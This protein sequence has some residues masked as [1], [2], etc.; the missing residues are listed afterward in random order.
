MKVLITGGTGLVGGS[1]SE[2]LLAQN[3]EVIIMSRSIKKSETKGLSYAHWDIDKETIE[4]D[5]V[6]S[7]DHIIHLAGANIGDK[8]WTSKQKEIMID[9]R[10]KT[11]NLLFKTLKENNHKVKTFISASGADCYGLETTDKYYQETDSF[12]NDFLAKV[13]KKW[14]AAANQFSDLGI[15][16]VCLRTGVVF[17]SH[18]SALQ[19]MAFPIQLGFGS[20]IGSGEQIMSIIHLKDLC[21]MY[22]YALNNLEL[23]GSYNAVAVNNT[24]KEVTKK[25]ASVLRK[26]LFMP[27]VPAFM[28][29]LIFGEMATILLKGSAVDNAKIKSTGFK[30]SYPTLQEILNEV[31]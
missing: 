16:T 30:F 21:N 4:T 1:L 17:A 18:N 14:E 25:I 29:K 20:A 12:G 11:A 22:I 23:Q 7:A 26:P 5:A 28:L 31:F 3:M 19:K 27:K 10:V 2:V 13:C 24:N 15:R 8:R 6:C 9:S